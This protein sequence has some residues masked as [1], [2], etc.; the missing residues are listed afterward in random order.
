MS[1]YLKIK[2]ENRVLAQIVLTTGACKLGRPWF[3]NILSHPILQ[4]I[5]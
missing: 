2:A 4:N 1:L 5:V 3:G